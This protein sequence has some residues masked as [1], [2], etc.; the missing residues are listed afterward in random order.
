MA[1]TSGTIWSVETIKSSHQDDVQI[2]HV[3]FNMSGTYAQADD[4]QLLSVAAAIEDSRRNGKTVTLLDGMAGQQARLASDPSLMMSVATDAAVAV[5]GSGRTAG[6]TFTLT[7]GSVA[8][9][10]DTTTE[11]TDA[12]AI[13]AQSTPFGLLVAFTEA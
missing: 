6:F 9:T 11:H 12:T 13:G 1:V 5:T 7:L 4:S 2:A 3:L 8:G 10:P